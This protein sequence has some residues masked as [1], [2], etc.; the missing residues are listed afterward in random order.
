MRI[1]EP[2]V[3]G[4][5]YPGNQETLR[6]Q[7]QSL[8]RNV[9]APKVRG[10][11]YGLIVPHAGYD[12]SGQTAAY[13]FK[14][15]ESMEYNTVILIG[16]SHQVRFSGAA[17]Y[18][19]G[20]W[21][22]P[23]G[24]VEIDSEFAS[25]LISQNESIAAKI[26]AH[27]IEHSLEVE[28]PLLQLVLKNFKFLPICMG[29]QSFETCKLLADA[30]VKA[31][32]PKE[33]VLLV[34]SSDFYHG[35]SYEECK[36][37]LTESI[38]LISQY[39]YEKFHQ[40]F[41]EGDAACGGGC[42]VTAM[43]ALKELGAKQVTLLHSTNSQDVTGVPGYVVGYG[44]FVFTNPGLSEEEKGLLIE[45]ARNSITAAV[46]G[47]PT[48]PAKPPKSK[49]LTEKR[50]CFVTI[51]KQSELRGCIGYILPFKPLY[52]AVREMAVEATL[53][54]P[55]FHPVTQD[56]LSDLKIEISVLSELQSVH[57]IDEIQVGRDGLYIKH[58][59]QSGLLLPQ[60]AAEEGWDR[61]EFLEQTC[62]KA[63]L[64]K[65]AWKEAEIYK[66]QAEIFGDE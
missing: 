36:H 39:N 16:P 19:S 12:Y 24:D 65:D 66:F 4:Q 34:A 53:H 61:L 40:T 21:R 9:K 28:L 58:G 6:R 32:T 22:T 47:E 38:S 42:I 31:E 25:R 7:V 43:L 56:E 2:V 35:Y 23:L 29:D 49:R 26:E 14:Q 10:K 52:Q 44:S 41:I 55:R 33:N 37:S 60:V 15:I 8:L 48:K 57:S 13:A 64:P 1:R 54:D 59:A 5:F 46:I 45:F 17:I 18:P 63:G 11:I 62:F 3:A 20:K 30:I 51:K 50:S 27:A